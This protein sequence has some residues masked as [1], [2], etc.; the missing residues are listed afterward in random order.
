MTIAFQIGRT[1]SILR[2]RP[3][4]IPST[5]QWTLNADTDVETIGNSDDKISMEEDTQEQQVVQQEQ[6]EVAHV[7]PEDL[8][9][10]E[11]EQELSRDEQFMRLA[12]ELA[13][14]EYVIVFVDSR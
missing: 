2:R 13:E 14:E 4:A 3:A 11:D 12:I 8:S 6:E 7:S 5:R 1:N 9:P 10:S